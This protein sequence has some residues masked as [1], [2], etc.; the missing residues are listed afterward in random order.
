MCLWRRKRDTR[1]RAGG[2][3]RQPYRKQWSQTKLEEERRRRRRRRRRKEAKRRIREK[4]RKKER[5]EEE[6]VGRSVVRRVG[7]NRK[8]IRDRRLELSAI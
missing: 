5:K 1:K 2:D 4:E 3:E 7:R 6:K 8:E